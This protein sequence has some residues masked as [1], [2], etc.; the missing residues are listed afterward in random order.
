MRIEW[1]PVVGL[2]VGV[3]AAW[4]A[5]LS[6]RTSV[7][8]GLFVAAGVLLFTRLDGTPDPGWDRERS[9]RRHGA[10]GEVQDLAW[11]MV[12]R[13]VALAL[14]AFGMGDAPE[15]EPVAV[16]TRRAAL[17]VRDLVVPGARRPNIA[18]VTPDRFG[19]SHWRKSPASGTH[20]SAI[21]ASQ[22]PRN[23]GSATPM[24][25]AGW[26][27]TARTRPT[28]SWMPPKAFCHT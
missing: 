10:R 3:L 1:R 24:T 25:V 6:L 14:D 17:E 28:T 11:A 16:P 20:R 22:A 26:P 21:S 15:P 13:D 2:L 23:C 5:G 19:C 18:T 12:G 8:I 7:L 4:A 9:A 27:L